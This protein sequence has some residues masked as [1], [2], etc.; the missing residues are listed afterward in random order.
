V[1]LNKRLK[2]YF[3]LSYL[4][5]EI[6]VSRSLIYRA[7]LK[8]GYASFT[9]E[10]LEYCEIDQLI[11]REQYYLDTIKPEYNLSK[12]AGS[13]LGLKHT[14]EA[15]E[16]IRKS[17]L[18]IPVSEERKLIA[19]ITSATALPVLVTAVETNETKVFTSIRA[20]SD[21]IGIHHSYL[22]KC[23][24]SKGIYNSKM[25]IV[26]LLKKNSLDKNIIISIDPLVKWLR[27]G[28]FTATSWVRT[29]GGLKIRQIT[30]FFF[31][32]FTCFN[33]IFLFFCK[34][35]NIARFA[36]KIKGSSRNIFFLIKGKDPSHT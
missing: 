31:F 20:A 13:V 22:A 4:R 10:I 17:K 12:T 8:Y 28:I 34:K 1:D 2:N 19:A 36:L 11:Q 3:N 9:L 16:A 26:K 32:R 15:I 14:E 5:R 18:G 33:A 25:Y 23:I 27:H 21:Y 30:Y 7:L 6:T 24:K 35:Q 29:P